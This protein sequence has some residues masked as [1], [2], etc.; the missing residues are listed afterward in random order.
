MKRF[1]FFL[2][3]FFIF[4]PG[5]VSLA[6]TRDF[7]KNVPE[8]SR[9]YPCPGWRWSQGQRGHFTTINGTVKIFSPPVVVVKTGKGDIYLRVGPWWFWRRAGYTLKRGEKIE[10][11]G[12]IFGDYLIPSKIIAPSGEILLRDKDGFPLWRGGWRH[13][14]RWGW[15]RP[16]CQGQGG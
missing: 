7:N 8:H 5:G 15:G 11:R 3:G 1:L 2:L 4:F 13:R 6:G 16:C 10:A 14:H 9:P 12:Y